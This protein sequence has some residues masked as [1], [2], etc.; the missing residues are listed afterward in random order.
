M[1]KI[2]VSLLCVVCLLSTTS[3]IYA[4]KYG[5]VNLGNLLTQMPE[6][7]EGS[8]QLEEYQKTISEQLQ[9]KI[10]A[11]EKEVQELSEKVNTLPPVEVKSKEAK[12]LEEQELIY[13]EEQLLS[14]K[15]V[16]KRK[17]IMGP[18]LNKVQLAID[19]IGKEQGYTMIFDAS[20]PNT[21]LYV[22][23]LV[24]LSADVLSKLGIKKE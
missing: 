3:S 6:V 2:L 5:Y 9:I 22:D 16:E 1:K 13:K 24:D 10:N 12:L 23:E 15:M 8:I 7:E 14:L 18:I 17:E 4:Q 19:A 20:V 11:W 21:M